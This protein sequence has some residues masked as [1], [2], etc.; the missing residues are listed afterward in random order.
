MKNKNNC[1]DYKYRL[2]RLEKNENGFSLLEVLIA[3]VILAIGLLGLSQMQVMG[4]DG[5]ARGN[6]ITTA[7]TLAQDA[8]EG[9][10]NFEYATLDLRL[11]A[12]GIQ[13]NFDSEFPEFNNGVVAANKT[14][15]GVT[16]T[17]N[18]TVDRGYPIADSMT[19]VVT[20]NWVDQ[21]GNNHSVSIDTVKRRD[22]I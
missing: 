14:Y 16:Y 6:K 12:D 13:G 15:K 9:L 19:I 18:Y 22:G 4:I 1:T 17:R 21:A 11:L 7:T 2:H 10:L 8:L 5:N 20:V 3:L